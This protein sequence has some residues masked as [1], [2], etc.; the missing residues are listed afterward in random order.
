[1]FFKVINYRGF[2]SKLILDSVY[3]SH[4]AKDFNIFLTTMTLIISTRLKKIEKWTI[5]MKIKNDIYQHLC[6]KFKLLEIL[7]Q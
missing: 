7:I 2:L 1:M 5:I 4:C 3:T 6:T